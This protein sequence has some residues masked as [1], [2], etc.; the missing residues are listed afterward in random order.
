MNL[1]ESIIETVKMKFPKEIDFP[2]LDSNRF[3]DE[4]DE[5]E[6]L[7]EEYR[8]FEREAPNFV[9]ICAVANEMYKNAYT[10][11]IFPIPRCCKEK[12]FHDFF[13]ENDLSISIETKE[14]M[15][16]IMKLFLDSKYLSFTN[17]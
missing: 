13:S 3:F 9:W 12:D 5:Y 15:E 11:N 8:F 6:E 2:H 17:F 14:Q 7:G 4:N 1:L 16:L 10:I